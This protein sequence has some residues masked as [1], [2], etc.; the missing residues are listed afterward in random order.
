MNVPPEV[1]VAEALENIGELSAVL[2]GQIAA[3]NVIQ[4]AL[5][6]SLLETLPPVADAMAKHLEVRYDLVDANLS[7]L[8]LRAFQARIAQV[9]TL[10]NSLR[11]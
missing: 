2:V 3:M 10:V 4:D 1:H 8:Q 9:S 6:S 5:I 7:G 11:R